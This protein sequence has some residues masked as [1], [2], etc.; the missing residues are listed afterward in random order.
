MNKIVT[1]DLATVLKIFG[2]EAMR[3]TLIQE[4]QNV[5]ATYGVT[6]DRRHLDLIGDYMTYEG[7]CRPFNRMGTHKLT[8][9]TVAADH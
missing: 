7:K 8:Y 4:I 2:A 5:F 1:N 3:A 9:I 6:V